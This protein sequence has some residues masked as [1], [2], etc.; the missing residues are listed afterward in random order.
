MKYVLILVGIA[1][2]C[3]LVAFALKTA[4]GTHGANGTKATTPTSFNEP[5]APSSRT[6]LAT[7]GEY[8]LYKAATD[9]SIVRTTSTWLETDPSIQPPHIRQDVPNL[10]LFGIQREKFLELESG[11]LV[12]MALPEP[13]Q[14]ISVWVDKVTKNPSGSLTINGKV[15]GYSDYSFVM[16]LGPESTFATIGTSSGVFNLRG[17]KSHVWIGLARSFNH[18]V[19]PATPDYRSPEPELQTESNS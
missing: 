17:N 9:Q 12:T 10:S 1:T 18:H 3:L 4:N 2:T 19:N 11:D 14:N 13:Q 16:T 15:D 5:N 6:T 8:G 7:N